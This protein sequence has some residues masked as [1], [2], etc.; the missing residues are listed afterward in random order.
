MHMIVHVSKHITTS[1]LHDF[2]CL[3][4]HYNSAIFSVEECV[5]GLLLI[6]CLF[7]LCE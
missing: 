2:V 7:V 6:V 1:I 3:L 5:Q 4:L